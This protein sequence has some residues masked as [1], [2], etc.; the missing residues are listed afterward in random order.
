MPGRFL[1]KVIN[2]RKTWKIPGGLPVIASAEKKKP[3]VHFRVPFLF[4]PYFAPPH[5]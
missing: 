5:A 2:L 1:V 4:I 3:S